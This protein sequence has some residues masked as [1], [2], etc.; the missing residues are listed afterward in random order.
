MLYYLIH[1]K[2]KKFMDSRLPCIILGN[3]ANRRSKY[4]KTKLSTFKIAK[5]ALCN[6]LK[7]FKF[8]FST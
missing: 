5:T 8:I 3:V 1:L 2:Q 7:M 6:S 4:I